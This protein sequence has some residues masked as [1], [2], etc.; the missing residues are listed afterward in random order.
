LKTWN[1]NEVNIEITVTVNAR[2]ESMADNVFERIDIGFSNNSNAVTAETTIESTKSSWWGNSGDKGDFKIDYE[3]SI[4]EAASLDLSNKYGDAD[5]GSIGGAANIVVKY[6]D[7]KLESVNRNTK[8]SLGY[9]N[10]TIGRLGDVGM[11][12]KYSKLK[13]REAGQ[14]NIESKYSKIYIEK[15]GQMKSLSKYDTYNLGEVRTLNSQGKYDHFE[16]EKANK[17]T[18]YAKYSD[19]GII[20]LHEKGTFE[21]KYGNVKIKSLQN[22]FDE[23]SLNC[24]YTDCKIYT[25]GGIDFELDVVTSHS[26]VYYPSDMNVSYEQKKNSDH[27]VKG[28]R[29]RK[30][31]G[32]IKARMRYGGIKVK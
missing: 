23:V 14:V 24:E 10:A 28:H 8:I 4:P 7:F 6:G 15:S 17:I 20:E 2:N 5:I 19:F 21:L 16:I 22:G 13:I 29:G 32:K 27:E 25:N 11:D 12:I 18:A 1:R 9:G 31:S 30:G 26:S 3:V